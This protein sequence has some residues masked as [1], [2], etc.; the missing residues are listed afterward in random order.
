M[1][2]VNAVV[3]KHHKKEN[4]TWNVKIS[5]SHNSSTKYIETSAYIGKSS[6]DT[7]GKLKKSYVEQNFA[8]TLSD[9][10]TQIAEL[11]MRVKYMSCADIK[12]YLLTKDKTTEQI[13]V[14]KVI[15]SKVGSLLY[16]QRKSTAD[17]YN[18]LDS[19]LK[20]FSRSTRL[21]TINITPDFIYRFDQYLRNCVEVSSMRTYMSKFNTL[22]NEM[23]RR[24]N[25]P[26]LNYFPIPYNPL[27]NYILP[28]PAAKKRRNLT[29]DRIKQIIEHRPKFNSEQTA[30]DMFLLSFMLCGMNSK[31]I[32]V[33]LNNPKIRGC[34]EYRRSKVLE[35]KDGGLI[36]INIPAIAEPL[37][38]KYG[39]EIQKRF[40]NNRN[41]NHSLGTAWV[42]L[43][44]DLGF[45]CSMYY[46]RHS[47]ANIARQVCKFSKEEVALAL[48]HKSGSDIT[49][50][51]IEPDWSVVHKVQAGVIN[52][53]FGEGG[54]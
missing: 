25:N 42:S 32:Y 24:Y 14:F 53:V 41:F 45:K 8:K 5:V 54:S 35:R 23:R 11:G 9:Y 31:D 50:V 40:S 21:D 51:Y 28:V 10:R 49:D 2:T 29:I 1:A 39:G 22:F 17:I 3:L 19:H 18:A 27:D 6:L 44:V 16:N 52:A 15:E 38:Q 4:G 13:D 43:S 7:K 30:K 36:N 34:I 26:A 12:E 47:F 33:Y 37:I 46:A 48:N 20:K